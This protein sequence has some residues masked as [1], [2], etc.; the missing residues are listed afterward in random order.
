MNA[1]G[2]R[3]AGRTAI[4][5]GSAQGIGRG[6]AE[7]FARERANVVIADINP[8]AGHSTAEEIADRF[9]VQAVFVATD[10]TSRTSSAAL[11]GSVR[12]RFG[13]IDVLCHNAGIYPPASIEETTDEL[14]DR[15]LTTNLKSALIMVSAVAAVMKSQ[16]YG[17]IVFTSSITGPIT[18][19]AGYTH[20]GAS[21]AGILGFM[22]SAAIEL[23]E[24]GVTVNAVLPGNI[25]T[26]GMIAQGAEY[27]N[28]QTRRIPMRRLGTPQDIGHAMLFFASD[29]AEYVTGQTLIVDGG[30][31]LPEA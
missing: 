28:A 9:G 22:R 6:I 30:Q 20:Y 29:E 12:D 5:T 11:A 10:V 21:K 1:T 27:M 13:R 7:V 17:R 23:A 16:K 18:G 14:W 24:H 25:V 31:V 19:I 3:L 2:G 8:T 15:V 26:P 4:V